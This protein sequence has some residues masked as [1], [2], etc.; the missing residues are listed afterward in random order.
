MK[1]SAS[2][3]A[4]V[5]TPPYPSSTRARN[6]SL[7][8]RPLSSPRL[9]PHSP[10]ARNISILRSICTRIVLFLYHLSS[11]EEGHPLTESA[12]DVTFYSPHPLH[13]YIQTNQ[14][15]MATLSP[16]LRELRENRNQ[17]PVSE[18]CPAR[19]VGSAATPHFH[20]SL[21]TSFFRYSVPS[22]VKK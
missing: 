20:P 6:A 12:R 19:V 13:F 2:P 5:P 15:R 1:P 18:S 17:E 22:W 16:C 9:I 21:A 11:P 7:T 3:Q 14:W 10:H 4:F 8:T